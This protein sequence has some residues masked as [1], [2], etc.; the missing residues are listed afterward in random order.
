MMEDD[1]ESEQL[2]AAMMNPMPRPLDER[3]PNGASENIET[4]DEENFGNYVLLYAYEGIY[5]ILIDKTLGGY[6]PLMVNETID[7]DTAARTLT[8]QVST[9][10]LVA[11]IKRQRR[12]FH[13]SFYQSDE[14][15]KAQLGIPS[16]H[17]MA[18]IGPS[19]G[20]L[21]TFMAPV[22]YHHRHRGHAGKKGKP[23]ALLARIIIAE[24]APFRPSLTDLVREKT[25]F[26]VTMRTPAL[27]AP[28][29]APLP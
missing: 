23:T 11:R 7:D 29:P 5:T 19:S 16:L 17:V 20:I 25:G 8:V 9:L 14:A 10:G 1:E 18:R 22:L 27:A 2:A 28:P 6:P 24:P 26:V 21:T 15:K 12:A 13:I 3:Q 4:E